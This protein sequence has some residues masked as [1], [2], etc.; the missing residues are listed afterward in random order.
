MDEHQISSSMH[1]ATNYAKSGDVSIAYQVLDQPG[2]DLVFVP[3]L[4]SSVDIIWSFPAPTRFFRRLAAFSRLIL[5][6]K[7]GQGASDA[8]PGDP[9][10]EQ[11]MED[12]SAVLDAVG[13]ERTTLI[14]YSEG[15]PVSALFAA[16]FPE[17]TAGLIG[18]ETAAASEDVLNMRPET[19]AAVRDAVDHWG[20]GRSLDLFG[21]SIASEERRRQFGAVERAIGSPARIR[22]RME[23][24]FAADVRAVLPSVR[25]PTLVVHRADERVMPPAASRHLAELIP[26]ARYVELP[27]IDHIPWLGDSEAILDE[28]EEFMMGAAPDRAGIEGPPGL[29]RAVGS[30][31]LTG[32]ELEVLRLVAAGKSNQQ[33]AAELVISGHTVRRHVQNIFAKVGVSSRAAATAFAFRHDLI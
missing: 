23:T 14:G 18:L 24:A 11:D 8:P 32:R 5:Y 22:A 31:E 28:I 9:T 2:P 16:T 26:D 10:L 13:A 30:H 12:L 20:E 33:I 27:G 6:D 3:G 17:R 29:D 21:P 25:A 4:L 19:L 1:P 15:G 7:R